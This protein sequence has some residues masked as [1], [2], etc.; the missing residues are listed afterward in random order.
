MIKKIVGIVVVLAVLGGIGMLIMQR[1]GKV[2]ET[3][4]GYKQPVPVLPAAVKTDKVKPHDFVETIEVSGEVRPKRVVNVFPKVGGRVEELNVTLGQP[5]TK[6]TVLA[7][8]EE[9]DLGFREKQGEAGA[10]AASAQVR[11]AQVQFENARVEYNRADEL[12]K[13]NALPEADLIRARGARNAAEAMWKSAQA[14][15]EVAKA[16]SDLAKEAKSWTEVEAPIDGVVTK[17]MTELGAVAGTQQPMLEIQ[18]QSSLQIFVDVPPAALDSVAVGKS[19]K[20]TVAERPGK[21]W[22]ATV[23]ATGKSL[24][25]L[26]RRVHVEL[27][28]PGAVVADGVLPLMI[29]TVELETARSSALLAAPVGAL[30]QLAEGPS[31]WV[32]REKKATRLVPDVTKQDATHV[33]LP[34]AK[35]D[36]VVVV[37]G[38]D[39]LKEGAEVRLVEEAKTAGEK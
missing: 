36:D 11:A 1:A 29:A 32:I 2:M 37:E 13:A 17:K 39:A 15:V 27:E 19:V 18:D 22:Q 23:T 21:V 12:F 10:R 30:I 38:Q 16:G 14:Q 31:V 8:I 35:A 9:N 25:P 24:D 34:T 26:T 7:K 28:V 33:A 20:F 5:I 3:R 6:G 4:E